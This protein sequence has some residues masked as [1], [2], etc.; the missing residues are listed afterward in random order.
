MAASPVRSPKARRAP[1][2]RTPTK[3]RKPR[4]T[5]Q[6]IRGRVTLSAIQGLIVHM[7]TLKEGRKQLIIVSEGW[8][9][10][11]PLTVRQANPTLGGGSV[12]I[13]PGGNGIV[14]P[15][16]AAGLNDTQ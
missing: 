4:E 13:A 15:I 6:Q 11:L 8:S 1:S 16:G 5:P 7:G 12:G 10:R 3:S 9:N 14:D 2:A